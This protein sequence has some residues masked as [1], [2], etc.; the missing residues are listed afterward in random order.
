MPT[1]DFFDTPI[2]P[3]GVLQDEAEVSLHI[4]DTDTMEQRAVRAIVSTSRDKL[5]GGT[6][7]RLYTYGR[8]GVRIESEWYIHII[9]ELNEAA[10]ATDHE[11]AQSQ[12]IEQSLKSAEQF[13]KSR[14]RKSEA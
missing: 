8:L 10:L 6:G 4:R 2:T 7:D 11:V 9:E 5:P 1:Y 13:K 12:D 14:Y 3:Y